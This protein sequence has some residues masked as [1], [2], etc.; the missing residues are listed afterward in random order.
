[1]LAAF[2]SFSISSILAHPQ[3][4]VQGRSQP[5]ESPMARVQYTESD[6][7]TASGSDEETFGSEEN[8][9]V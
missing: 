3:H 1:M 5:T 7:A 9:D 4:R 6:A 2:G 8:V